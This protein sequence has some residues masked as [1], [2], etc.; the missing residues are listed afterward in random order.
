MNL[1]ISGMFLYPGQVGGTEQYFYNLLKG[2]DA[3]GKNKEIDIAIQKGKAQQMDAILCRFRIREQRI[4]LNRVLND[5]LYGRIGDYPEYCTHLFFPNYVSPLLPHRGSRVFTTI[6]DLLYLTHPDVFTARKR[7]WLRFA[8]RAA[9]RT[10]KSVIA[11]SEFVKRDI[12]DHYPGVEESLVKVIHNP[13]DY[14]R[15]DGHSRF[16]SGIDSPF[17]LSVANSYPHKNLHTLIQGYLKAFPDKPRPLKLVLAGQIGKSLKGGDFVAYARKIE[18]LLSDCPD[19][20][21]TG[22]ISDCEL[23][24]LYKSASLFCFPSVFEG[25]GMPVVEAMG[26]GL[27]TLTTKLTSIPEVSLNRAMYVE[28]AENPDSWAFELHRAVANLDEN[29]AHFN[30]IRE[31]IRSAYCPKVVAKQYWDLFASF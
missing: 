14:A 19:I 28:S 16:A 25:F 4:Y 1:Y 3:I 22:Y 10:S 23:G 30:L 7:K 9:L 29:K 11:I 21:Q 20:I 6:H 2:F 24:G 13:V 8:H 31:G 15:F 18:D 26:F 17:I 12:L 5:C 27:P